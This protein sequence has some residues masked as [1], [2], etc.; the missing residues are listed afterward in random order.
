MQLLIVLPLRMIVQAP[1]LPVSH[2][3]W[4]PFSASV[5]RMKWTSSCR[6]S[7]VRS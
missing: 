6:A 4:V 7:T 5:S 1:Q 3:M 2:P